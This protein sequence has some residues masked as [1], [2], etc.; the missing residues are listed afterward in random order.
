MEEKLDKTD[1]GAIETL[2]D[3]NP[4][5]HIARGVAGLILRALLFAVMLATVYYGA[6]AVNWTLD[7]ISDFAD[8][9]KQRAGDYASFADD[10]WKQ[11]RKDR[12]SSGRAIWDQSP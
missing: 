10:Y 5:S 8:T 9:T 11:Q 1:R 2:R 3:R 4:E 7:K 12:S 6:P